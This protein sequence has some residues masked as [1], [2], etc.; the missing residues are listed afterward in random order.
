MKPQYT[1]DY[2]DFLQSIRD[3]EDELAQQESR[4]KKVGDKRLRQLAQALEASVKAIEQGASKNDIAAVWTAYAK[5]DA[6]WK[7]IAQLL[8][9]NSNLPISLI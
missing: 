7:P 3:R 5:Q 9:G 4:R 2:Y 6:S 8:F 1:Q